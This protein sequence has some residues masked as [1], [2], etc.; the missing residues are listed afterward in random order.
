[1]NTVAELMALARQELSDPEVGASGQY[2]FY[3]DSEL[4]EF[5]NNAQQE[6]SVFTKCLPD[7]DSFSVSLTG[8]VREYPYDTNIIEI[9]GG[10]IAAT[11][12]RVKVDSFEAVERRYMLNQVDIA[13]WGEWEN[14]TGVPKYII[15]DLEVDKIVLYPTPAASGTLNLYAYKLSNTVSLPSDNLEI[16]DQ[17]RYGLIFRIMSQ[18]FNKIDTTNI[19]DSAKGLEFSQRWQS[20]LQ[21]AKAFYDRRF[22]RAK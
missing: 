6:F 3:K 18:A 13:Q 12:P 14:E 22:K 16:P 11:G 5:I 8:G 7:Y 9:V 19:E 20:F 2:S 15:P 10:R 4:I 1:M 21:D 17:H